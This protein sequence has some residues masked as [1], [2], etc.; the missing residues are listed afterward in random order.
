MKKII[1]IL[2]L[3]CI[4]MISSGKNTFVNNKEINITDIRSS[5]GEYYDELTDGYLRGEII[6]TNKELTGRDGEI[7]RYVDKNGNILRYTLLLYGETG[8]AIYDYYFIKEYIYVNVLD[9]K[10]MCPVY[11]KTTY[12]LYR[13]LKE[14]VIYGNLLYK[15]EKGEAIESELEDLGLLYRTEEELSN[16][17]NE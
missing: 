11:E 7:T 4:L 2:L 15:F 13:T 12:T 10:Y 16:L 8:K 9:E 14:G 6:V 1:Y 17:I 5:I 3:S